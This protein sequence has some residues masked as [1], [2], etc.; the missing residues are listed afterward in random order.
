MKI[1]SK[2]PKTFIIYIKTKNDEGYLRYRSTQIANGD[3]IFSISLEKNQK[4]SSRFVNF[5]NVK[6]IAK[7]YAKNKKDI[8]VKIIDEKL[9][10]NIK[11]K[12]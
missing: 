8:E 7:Q 5:D 10:K 6:R 2:I 12:V 1:N 11:I 4:D 3:I 9:K